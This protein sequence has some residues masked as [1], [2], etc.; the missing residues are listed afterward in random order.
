MSSDQQ[1]TWQTTDEDI[2]GLRLF[3]NSIA[4]HQ[5]IQQRRLADAAERQAA[6]LERIAAGFESTLENASVS[7]VPKWSVRIINPWAV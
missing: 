7:D 4:L 1:Q 3:V 5:L 6:A 2:E